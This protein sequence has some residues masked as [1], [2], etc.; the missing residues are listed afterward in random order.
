MARCHGGNVDTGGHV[1]RLALSIL[2]APLL[3]FAQ[4]YPSGPT[5][6][7]L[8]LNGTSGTAI[9]TTGSNTIT[10]GI[11]FSSD[12][13]TT[14]LKS[15]Q[16]TVDGNGNVSGASYTI[17]TDP[18][19]TVGNEF[20]GYGIAG[21][22]SGGTFNTAFGYKA[23]NA[24]TSGISNTA[25][26]YEAL[27]FTTT[28]IENTAVGYKALEA[29]TGS[30]NT[31]FGYFALVSNT[32][33]T[34]NTATGLD[35]AQF[36]STGTYSTAFGAFACQGTTG[37][38]TTGSFNTC[39]G[40]NAG[41]VV[42]GAAVN[43]TFVG[44]N[45]GSGTTTGTD[46]SAVGFDALEDNVTGIQNMAFGSYAL[47]NSTGT[48]Y[49]V[50]IGYSAGAYI[51]TGTN[52][53]AVGSNACVGATGAHTTG[54]YNTCIGSGAGTVVQGSGNSNVLI[55]TNAGY[56]VTTGSSN[57]VIGEGVASTTLTTGSNNL[58]IGTSNALDAAAAGTTNTIGV[59]AGSTCVWC[60][61]GA[62]TVT[63]AAETFHGSI[64]FPQVTTGTN[65]DFVCMAAGEV[66]TLQTSACTISSKR[67]K[68]NIAAFDGNAIGKL[69]AIP[70]KTFEMKPGA[71]PNPDPNYGSKQIGITAEDVARIEPRCAIYEN[72]MKTPKSYR[73]ECVIGLLVAAV[74]EQQKEINSLKRRLK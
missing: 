20:L 32:S 21:S 68:Q 24:L 47:T 59:G 46:N 52:N 22:L 10:T 28:G 7:S 15:N 34:F 66:L 17:G 30:Q 16:Y 50:G 36:V 40:A 13:M 4:T 23:E 70:V 65:A 42:Q 45:A 9:K 26:G 62:G 31:A 55:G 14:F 41:K 25:F 60:V 6:Q 35:A 43:N 8:I 2:F 57:T 5:V 73:Q 33:G 12:T 67:F 38:H 74:Q 19:S 18:G 63:T 49:N 71:Q 11:D 64:A 1:K 3:A 27:A 53:T 37:T 56:T 61:T 48:G 69:G 39:L 72:D 29:N 58:L 51:S 44:Y 54:S